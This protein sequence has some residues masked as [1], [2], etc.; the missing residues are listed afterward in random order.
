MYIY[1]HNHISFARM[2]SRCTNYPAVFFFSVIKST[3]FLCQIILMGF[4][5]PVVVGNVSAPTVS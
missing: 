3:E 2:G 5:D 1:S 4:S